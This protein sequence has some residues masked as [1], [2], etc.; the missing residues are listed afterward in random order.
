M[1]KILLLVA[2]LLLPSMVLAE[3]S[4]ITGRERSTV[5][6]KSEKAVKGRGEH[7]RGAWGY[8]RRAT[9]KARPRVQKKSK[10]SPPAY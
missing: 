9:T 10:A 4:A 5:R 2:A 8:D 7:S 6:K 1:R 3:R